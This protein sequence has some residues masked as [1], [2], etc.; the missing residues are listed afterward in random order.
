MTRYSRLALLLLAGCGS[1]VCTRHSDC[2]VG[3]VCGASASCET[4]PDL[5]M[6]S[7]GAPSGDAA[8]PSDSAVSD[9]AGTIGDGAPGDALSDALGA[10]DLGGMD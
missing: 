10:P 9:S 3:M 1:S 4:P 6:P 2:P 5:W 8:A 7:D